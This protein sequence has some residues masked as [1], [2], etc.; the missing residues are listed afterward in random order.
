MGAIAISVDARRLGQTSLRVYPLAYGCWRFAGTDVRTARTKIETALEL[1]INLFDHADIYGGNGAA[2]EL[3]GRVLDEA[4]H[5]RD[6]M[7][8][9]TKCGIVPGIPYDS[10]RNH[11][12]RSA[13]ESLHR[14]QVEVIDVYQVHR[15]DMLTHPAEV[16]AALTEL[17]EQGKIREVGVSNYSTHQ[18]ETLQS[19]LSFPIAT[20]QPELSAWFL[21]PLYNGILDQCM[22]FRVTPLAWSPLAGGRLGL[23]RESTPDELDNDRLGGLLACLDRV[24][25]RHAVSRTV[26]ALA[27][28]LVHPAGVIPII[29]TQQL[30]RIREAGM[31]LKVRLTRQEWYRILA[32]SLGKPLP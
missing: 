8:I 5:L 14:L 9:A 19:L 11:I 3:F 16:A 21:D 13:E 17:R 30:H 29:G 27:F 22:R 18:F 6:T 25:E 1:G 2:E 15:P 32:A 28:L 12:M 7:V 20:N 10:T 26:I 24:A 31:A 4:P 23:A